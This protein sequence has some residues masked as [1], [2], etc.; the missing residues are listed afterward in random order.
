MR[1]RASCRLGEKV[2]N[3]KSCPTV[4]GS[5]LEEDIIWSSHVMNDMQV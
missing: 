2:A 4:N 3:L 5:V 1:E